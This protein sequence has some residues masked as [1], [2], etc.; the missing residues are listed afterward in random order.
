[1]K[2]GKV[3]W[4]GGEFKG[5]YSSLKVINVDGQDQRIPFVE[6]LAVGMDPS[7]GEVL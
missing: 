5:A 2:T 7:S 6:N 1:M 4:F 3:A